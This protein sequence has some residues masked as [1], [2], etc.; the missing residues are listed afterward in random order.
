MLGVGGVLV[1]GG[2]GGGGGMIGLVVNRE[3]KRATFSDPA[4]EILPQDWLLV[5][6]LVGITL[7][8]ISPPGFE[9]CWSCRAT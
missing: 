2:G 6:W 3:N 5:I 4:R 8:I 7:E 1:E 9:F